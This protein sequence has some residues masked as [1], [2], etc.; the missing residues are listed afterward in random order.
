MSL[1]FRSRVRRCPNLASGRSALSRVSRL[2]AALVAVRMCGRAAAVVDAAYDFRSD[3][4]SANEPSRFDAHDNLRSATPVLEASTSSR[5]ERQV[6]GRVCEPAVPTLSGR[7]SVP[8]PAIRVNGSGPSNCCDGMRGR[9]HTWTKSEPAYPA[10][11]L[12]DPTLRTSRRYDVG[13]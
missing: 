4:A 12:R 13:P 2:V 9:L 11:Q 10:L 6:P 7:P 5:R 8:K 3:E 1:S